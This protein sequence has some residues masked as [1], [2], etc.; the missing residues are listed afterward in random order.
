[1]IDGV[2][3][4]LTRQSRV[5]LP[6][7]GLPADARFARLVSQNRDRSFRQQQQQQ[8]GVTGRRAA[9]GALDSAE[10]SHM[11]DVPGAA[12]VAA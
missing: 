1:M 2:R 7:A 5:S 9:A 12:R 8:L 10:R 6:T 3:A 4:P 11:R